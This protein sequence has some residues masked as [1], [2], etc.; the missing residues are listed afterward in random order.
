ML[1]GLRWLAM[2]MTLDPRLAAE[3]KAMVALAFR[4]GP[5]ENLYAGK[6]CFV[7]RGNPGI[8]HISDEEM[9]AMMKSAVDTLYRLLWQRENDPAAYLESPAFGERNTI[10][11]DDPELEKPQRRG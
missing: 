8:S 11:W 6:Q 7:C 5:I 4:N 2:K 9:K 10:N 1:Q 3:S